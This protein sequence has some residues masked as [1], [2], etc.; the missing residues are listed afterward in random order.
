[1]LI[2]EKKKR[3]LMTVKSS[4]LTT[5]KGRDPVDFFFYIVT[6]AVNHAR[7]FSARH[8]RKKQE[9]KA[10]SGNVVVTRSRKKSTSRNE[11]LGKNTFKKIQKMKPTN[12]NQ[13]PHDGLLQGKY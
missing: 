11:R 1:M 12:E 2:C 3:D 9:E 13:R 4:E 5:F 10:N 6:A 8:T 7:L